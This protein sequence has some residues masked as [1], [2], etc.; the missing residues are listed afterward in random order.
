MSISIALA[1]AGVKVAAADYEISPISA[2]LAKEY[3]LEREFYK[4]GTLVQDILI[5]TSDQVSDH[6]HREA[7]YQFDMIMKSI[8]EAIA[9]RIRENKVLCILIGHRELTSDVPQFKTDKTG[10]ELDFYNWRQRGFLTRINKRP[11][12]V[13]AEEDVL[14]YEGGMQLE[15]ILIHEFGHVIHGAG[16]DDALQKRLTEVFQRA[17]AK[18]IWMDGR[19][20]Q[21]YRRVKSKTPVS[22]LDALVK[23]FPDQSPDLIQRCLDGGDITV[24]GKPANSKVKVS[25]QDKVLIVFGG[26]KECYAHRNRAE[27]WAEGVQC[28]YNTNRTMDHDH[29]H[30]HTRAQLQAYDPALAELCADVLGES[31]WRFVSPRKRAGQDHLDGFDPKTS[32]RVVD[33]EHIENAAYDYYDKYWKNYWTRLRK[34]HSV[35][36]HPVPDSPRWLTY[37][38]RNDSTK[39]SPGR[40]KHIVLIAAEQEYRS[41]QSMPMLAKIL[42]HHH[43]FHCTVL[44]AVNDKNEVDPTQKIRWQDKTVTHNIPGLEH[45]A[46]ADLMILFSRL[47]TLPDEQIQHVIKYIDSGR[48]IIG[49]RTANHGFL[50]N[51]PY[52]KD[53]KRVRFGED[54]LGGSFRKH[55]GRWHADSTRGIFIEEAKSHPI[56]TG[57]KDIWGPSDVYRTYPEGK[58][59]PANCRALVLGQPL[60]GRRP[61]DGPNRE[62]EPL[63]IAWTKSWTGTTG[64]TARVFHVT[65]GSARDYQSAGLRRLT[66][67]ASYWCLGMEKQIRPDSSVEYVGEYRPLESGFNY[68]KLGVVPRKP[69]AYR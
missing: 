11:T 32:P 41:E 36:S 38:G 24:N 48:P 44:F 69:A 13:F 60:V 12:V 29:N 35:S 61:T 49:I 46:S 25:K 34:K 27:Y 31:E 54:V 23:S 57:V 33:P 62:K 7:A 30:I 18:G 55:H 39:T 51:F 37:A 56:L 63:P 59:L 5:A 2:E 14:E 53:G 6:A 8:D 65:M 21:R 10:K 50:E 66:V 40:G 1:F 15:S 42:S 22:L 26:E 4:K 19:A 45:L 20:A 16:F 28:W 43:G 67:N 3:G 64:K 17:R 52:Q 47:L 68:E 58:S 9:A